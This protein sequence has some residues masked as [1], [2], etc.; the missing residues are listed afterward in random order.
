MLAVLALALVLVPLAASAPLFDPDEGLHAAIAQEMVRSGDYIT[1]RFLGTP[2]LDKPILFFWTEALSLRLFGMNEAAVR[3]PPLLFGILGMIGVALLAR[4]L[5]DERV[6]ILSAIAY[7][8]MLLPLGVSEVAVHDVAVVPF[9]C[10]AA[11]MLVTVF[12]GAGLLLPAIVAGVCLGLSILTKGL[13][14]FAFTGIFAVCLVA[15]RRAAAIRLAAALTIAGLVAIVIA[16]PWYIAMEHAHPGYLH[17]YFIERHLEGYLTATQR[18]AGRPWWYYGPIV[19]AGALPWTGYLAAAARSGR[20]SPMRLVLW[21]W[22]ALGLIFLSLAESKLVTYVLPLFPALAIVAAECATRLPTS[23]SG[24]AV[25]VFTF[26]ALPAIGLVI[27][28]LRF[29][30]VRG[31]LWLPAL[32]AALL[33]LDAAARVRRSPGYDDFVRGLVW[34]SVC[35]LIG[36]SIVTPRAANWMTGKDLARALNASGALPAHVSVL[37]ERIG[38]VVFYLAPALR[39]RLAPDTIRTE[40]VSDAIQHV[41]TDPDDAIVAVR[42]TQLEKFGRLFASPPPAETTAGTFTLYRAGDLRAAL[43]THP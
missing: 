4:A 33:V 30:G 28:H 6:A 12:S 31:W 18:H 27:V 38:S 2:F 23:K 7:A 39:A 3:V 26:A 34:M 41:R 13:V 20:T 11:W 29:G 1:P 37:N 19:V 32:L 24:F 10:G 16:A 25:L 43:K 14:G 22:F 5:F 40:S 21:G 36:M 42:G 35:A 15:A 9:M 17:Y 8:T